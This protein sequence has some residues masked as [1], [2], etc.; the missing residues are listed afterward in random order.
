M[1]SL[2]ASSISEGI[3]SK[4]SP[5]INYDQKN[6]NSTLSNYSSPIEKK[7]FESNHQINKDAL[8]D[9]ELNKDWYYV[10][11][12]TSNSDL[13]KI[14]NDAVDD[15]LKEYNECKPLIFREIPNIDRQWTDQKRVFDQ[16]WQD[17]FRNLHQDWLESFIHVSKA[18]SEYERRGSVESAIK[19]IE[20]NILNLKKQKEHE[21]Q[22]LKKELEKFHRSI[23][24]WGKAIFGTGESM[25]L[26]RAQVE[27]QI[28][29]FS[30]IFAIE[31]INSTYISNFTVIKNNT[32]ILDE[33][34][35][36]LQ[37]HYET[38]SSYPE[39]VNKLDHNNDEWVYRFYKI[40]VYPFA[41][42]PKSQTQKAQ[43]FYIKNN[44]FL[45]SNSISVFF[46]NE[47][48]KNA[49]LEQ[50]LKEEL[51]NIG[52]ENSD[53]EHQI[54]K[55]LDVFQKRNAEIDKEIKE[56]EEDF[57]DLKEVYAL[58]PDKENLERVRCNFIRNREKYIK[59]YSQR[60]IL[61]RSKITDFPEPDQRLKDTF[62]SMVKNAWDRYEFNVGDYTEEILVEKG[63][64]ASFTDR[65]ISWKQKKNAFK[66]LYLS[67]RDIG[68]QPQYI[69]N[70]GIKIN[71]IEQEK[72]EEDEK[73]LKLHSECSKH[74]NI[75]IVLY[76]DETIQIDPRIVSLLNNWCTVFY[77]RIG[78]KKLAIPDDTIELNLKLNKEFF[79]ETENA[80]AAYLCTK[81]PYYNNYFYCNLDHIPKNMRI[82]SFYGWDILTKLTE[83]NGLTHFIASNIAYIFDFKFRHKKC[84]TGC[85]YDFLQH[86][87][88]ID[89]GMKS[90]YIC[91]EHKAIIKD[92]LSKSDKIYKCIFNDLLILLNKL[93]EASRNNKDIVKY[94]ID[95][96]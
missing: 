48:K 33:I 41:K 68:H 35:T 78:K 20:K 92:F 2:N 58:L 52:I 70:I 84:N 22:V 21:K 28:N 76:Q 55:S 64:L 13:I 32:L 95:N 67:R 40:E 30:G 53:T 91:S 65:K 26:T 90:S 66:I 47:N 14:I 17:E 8:I 59:H 12:N 24:V 93:G 85:I 18:K 3:L 46:E 6:L 51:H 29:Q 80:F 11:K 31:N 71:L 75:E 4:S 69:A 36:K 16:Y 23:L 88:G 83:N 44:H 57:D 60:L 15:K 34:K 74:K 50:W 81:K 5:T 49:F 79:P 38:V 87:T 1:Y 54:S 86:K 77:F 72:L 89:G 82:F 56:L 73:I 10:S 27:N 9:F 42:N 37:G 43:L 7:I 19:E 94:Y 62:V 63:E 25:D 61:D 96:K 39:P 45:D